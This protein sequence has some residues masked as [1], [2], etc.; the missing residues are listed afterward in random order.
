VRQTVARYYDAITA[1]D[2]EV[3]RRLAELDEDG[4]AANTIVF[5]Y[6]D[7]GM[8]LPRGKRTLYD[9]GLH[10]P[11]I[12]YFPPRWEH[13]APA[14]R[15]A[16]TGRLVSFVDFAP[17]ILSLAGEPPP[18][19]MQGR[20]FLGT[21]ADAPRAD[22]VGARDR[23]DEAY[24][25]ARAVRDDRFLY[26]RHYHPHR[27][28]N[29]PEYFSDQAA[30]RRAITERARAGTLDE[31]QR[32]YAG[33]A[34]PVEELF[35]TS[36]DAHQVHNLAGSPEH[37]GVLARMRQRLG[38]WQIATRDL[39]FLPES[40][41][42][43]LSE[44][45]RTPM[46]VA[47]DPAVYPLERILDTASLVGR[48]D[49]VAEQIA[50]LGDPNAVVRYWAGVG[51]V[52]AGR[53]AAPALAPL[54]RALADPAPELRIVAAEA[55]A[56]L[57]GSR[58]ALRTLEAALLSDQSQVVLLAARTLQLLGA[59]AAPARGAMEQVLARTQDEAAYGIDALFIRFALEPALS[60]PRGPTE[61]IEG[62]GRDM[63]P[64]SSAR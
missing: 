50:R 64:G 45:G 23:V 6:G 42:L 36:R 26:I 60:K 58:E 8:G 32:T 1:M 13:L 34:R 16:A 52:A 19:Y 22:V 21:R 11:L 41:A 25:L 30:M 3:G 49:A 24:D 31:A 29:Q 59:S 43:R 15:G 39:G 47:R 56:R 4:V 44:A 35:D 33:P 55:L 28:W 46:D 14:A 5:F 38:E 17:T 27:S 48:D 57:N 51:L 54:R 53:A 7:H 61:V 12:A 10:V 62:P 20:S 18:Q 37:A 63:P 2:A 9:S 40:M